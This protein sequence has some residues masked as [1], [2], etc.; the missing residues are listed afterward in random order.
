MIRIALSEFIGTF[1]LCLVGNGAVHESA[2]TGGSALQ[3]CFAFGMS[4]TFGIYISCSA[5]G[6]H[7]N[8]AVSLAMATLGRLGESV[9][10]NFAMFGV[11]TLAQVSGAFISSFFVWFAYSPAE[12]YLIEHSNMSGKVGCQ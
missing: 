5:S 3:T 4:V 7:I 9:G 10:K 6:G 2:L 12:E 1:F 11:Y 8:P